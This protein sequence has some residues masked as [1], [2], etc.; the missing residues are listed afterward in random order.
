M[1]KAIKN[2]DGS[3][4]LLGRGRPPRQAVDVMLGRDGQ[5][6]EVVEA[7]IEGQTIDISIQHCDNPNSV[8]H[9]EPEIEKPKP[10][11]TIEKAWVLTSDRVIDITEETKAE[12]EKHPHERIW[13]S[14]N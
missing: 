3:Y 9:E 13:L 12:Q 8:V 5:Y 6:H 2:P 1:P 11:Y 4:R 14:V 7:N 10:V